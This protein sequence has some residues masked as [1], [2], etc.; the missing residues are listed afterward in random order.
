VNRADEVAI[1]LALRQ[2]GA[3]AGWQ[4]DRHGVPSA[5]R[6]RR[7]ASGGWKGVLPG[8]YV[9]PGAPDTFEQRL[10]I[11]WLAVGPQAMVSFEAAAQLTKIPNV[12]RNRVT[13]TVPHSGYQRIPGITIHQLSDVLPDHVTS[14][15]GLKVTTVPRTIVDL[16]AVVQP[17]RLLRIVE[18]SKHAGLASYVE[19]GVCLKSVARRGKPG[20]RNMTRALGAFEDGK[21]APNSQLETR[22]LEALRVGQL[23]PPVAQYPFPGRQF[24]TGCV[25][26]AYVDAKLVLEADGRRWHTRIQDIARDHERDGDA[27]E[28]GWQTLRLLYEH[29]SGDPRG[30]ARRVRAVLER[31]LLQ[32]AS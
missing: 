17:S 18:D 15:D 21:A 30:T 32:L 24:V 10:W 20:V 9:M 6:T 25:D 3:F 31:R 16:A 22:L 11:G 27:A 1:E 23:P 19:M 13:L 28:Q 8:V 4:L 7:L 29:I 5:L 26:F 14:I 12:L 2:H